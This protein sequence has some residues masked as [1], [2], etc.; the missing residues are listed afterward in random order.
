MAGNCPI[1]FHIVCYRKTLEVVKLMEDSY[2][3][4]IEGTSR[5]REG[6]GS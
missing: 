3:L 6:A 2:I 5:W 1:I 4:N